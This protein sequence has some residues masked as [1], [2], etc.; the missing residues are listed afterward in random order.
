VI[1]RRRR[2]EA[3]RLLIDATA[4]DGVGMCS[5]LAPELITVDSWGFP[6]LSQRLLERS[7]LRLAK[8]AVA[9]C[10]RKALFIASE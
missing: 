2:P 9:G 4:C 10:P 6:I 5:H 1:G 7:E 8:S 3:G